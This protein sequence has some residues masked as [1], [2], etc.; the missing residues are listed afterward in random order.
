LFSVEEAMITAMEAAVRK[1]TPEPQLTIDLLNQLLEKRLQPFTALQETS[2]TNLEELLDRVI[3]ERR[4]EFAYEGL[5]WFDIKRF[6][7][8]VTHYTLS[9]N[10]T[11]DP[12]DLRRVVQIPL[13]EYTA[14]PKIDLNP[15]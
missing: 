4:R 13:S 2:F 6:G 12:D 11:L 5:R 7:I 10:I 3:E 15:R 14:N 9:G 1:N 8:P